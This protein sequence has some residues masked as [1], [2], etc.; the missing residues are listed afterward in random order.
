MSVTMLIVPPLS[1]KAVAWAP[2]AFPNSRII[3]PSSAGV[4]TGSAT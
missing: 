1:W 4:R 2:K 3:V